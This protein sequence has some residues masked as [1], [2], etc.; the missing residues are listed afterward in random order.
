[1]K[2]TRKH[3]VISLLL[4]MCRC[5][6]LSQ[7][8]RPVNS[9]GCALPSSWHGAWFQT[10]VPQP[11]YITQ[12]SVTSKGTC[13]QSSGT[14]FLVHNREAG[15]YQC[16][17]FYE[18]HAN[19]IHYKESYCSTESRPPDL[20]VMCRHVTG[21]RPLFALLRIDYQPIEC[22]L[23]GPFTFTYGLSQYGGGA[24]CRAEPRSRLDRCLSS[25]RLTFSYR[26][27]NNVPG[28]KDTSEDVECVAVWREGSARYLITR[29]VHIPLTY[30]QRAFRCFMLQRAAPDEQSWLDFRLAAADE[31]SCRGLL[32][33]GDGARQLQ[34][35]SAP[36]Y[37][38]CQLPYWLAERR[39]W[40]SLDGA[41]TY[42]LNS[43]NTSLLMLVER[44]GVGGPAGRQ[45]VGGVRRQTRI[46][47][48]D[49]VEETSSYATLIV[50][51]T[52]GCRGGFQCMRL[53]RRDTHVL[54]LQLGAV[55]FSED[56]VCA[57]FA[58]RLAITEF[59]TLVAA[60]NDGVSCPH[61]GAFRV[62]GVR[63]D[64]RL[65]GT[66]SG[67]VIRDLSVPISDLHM[68][69][70]A[71]DMFALVNR[72][73]MGSKVFSCRGSWQ[74]NDTNYVVASLRDPDP[75][76]LSVGQ[77]C[78]VSRRVDTDSGDSRSANRGGLEQRHRNRRRLL[79]VST[80]VGSC[81]RD[82]RPGHD[83]L[84]AMNATALGGCHV[85]CAC[86]AKSVW[87]VLPIFILATL[88][89]V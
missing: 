21:D 85:S 80:V 67:R 54:E 59:Q 33:V 72:V 43:L 81:Q 15:C 2:A 56:N 52:T 38:S 14:R 53:Y 76:D 65:S 40:R 79:Q 12:N 75:S 55:A 73:G 51:S 77:L 4:V 28:T 18:K 88:G 41:V 49:I 45:G 9:V 58:S 39:Q 83:G 74:E 63:R 50:R 16:L 10:G 20:Q 29:R 70:S 25:S 44:R 22:P 47:C 69:C 35:V 78:F 86:M 27:C 61:L 68:G 3:L 48:A 23:R 1:M 24:Q 87:L 64:P 6:H 13:V 37:G 42:R 5:T 57:E 84:L 19:I 8:S 31:A 82:I 26:R 60:G 46:D 32:A 30:P 34:L 71:P 17:I 11:I 66:L 36:P 7:A 62:E 89:S